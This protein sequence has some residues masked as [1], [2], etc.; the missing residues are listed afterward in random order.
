MQKQ[1]S[2]ASLC[3]TIVHDYLNNID[4]EVYEPNENASKA[5]D[6]LIKHYDNPKIRKAYL[7]GALQQYEDDADVQY[8]T[9][10][11]VNVIALRI[12]NMQQIGQASKYTKG[13]E[14]KSSMGIVRVH[15][16]YNQPPLLMDAG[17]YKAITIDEMRANTKDRNFSKELQDTFFT[18]YQRQEE[19]KS[20]YINKNIG[21]G[22]S[23]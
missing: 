18:Q 4:V 5:M 19:V 21:V 6:S 8:A 2:I 13:E 10:E 12:Q 11:I 16:M 20:S 17:Y 9:N 1:Q 7:E 22:R 15:S 23:K 3:Q 14:E